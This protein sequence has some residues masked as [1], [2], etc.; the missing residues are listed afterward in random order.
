M[1]FC[2]SLTLYGVGHSLLRAVV[3]THVDNPL[4]LSPVPYSPGSIGPRFVLAF[5]RGVEARLQK[6]TQVNSTT[7]SVC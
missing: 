7:Y 6:S 3:T 2:A 4:G 1:S 5:R